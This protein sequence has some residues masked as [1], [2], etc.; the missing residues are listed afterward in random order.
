MPG[1]V[2]WVYTGDSRRLPGSGG[3]SVK[4]TS[5]VFELGA[6]GPNQWPQDGIP[7]I[8]FIGRSNVGKSSLL[9]ALTGRKH[10]ARVSGKPGKT[11]QVNFYLI[12]SQFR[13]VD[14][15]GYGY[16]AISQRE[17]ASLARMTQSYLA[18]R[19]PLVR[20]VH[21]LD[22]RHD[23]MK[24]DIEFHQWL[25]QWSASLLVVATKS[26][27]IGKN[28]QINQRNRIAQVLHSPWPVVPV[29][30]EKR[31]GLDELWVI[32]ETDL[33]QRGLMEG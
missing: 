8:A 29:S 13:F 32:F 24:N 11:Q 9:N 7:E 3:S 30:A 14:L 23:P 18:D 4:V 31:T 33:R 12:N 17:R 22:I 28:L 27:K 10:L 19:G 1:G 21:L 16:A 25:Q 20:V 5:S 6:V 26:D 2:S 15:P